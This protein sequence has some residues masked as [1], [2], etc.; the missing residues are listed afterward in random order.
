MTAFRL[1]S[2]GALPL[3]ASDPIPALKGIEEAIQNVT[4][5]RTVDQ[6]AD[7][8]VKTVKGGT[9]SKPRGTP[10]DRGWTYAV[11]FCG[12]NPLF[13][14]LAGYKTL[15][16]SGFEII[17]FEDSVIEAATA[18]ALEIIFEPIGTACAGA[19]PQCRALW[20]PNVEAWVRTG[21][22]SYDGEQVPDL[23]MSGSARKST[24]SFGNYTVSGDL[25]DYLAHWADK[26][27]DI[28]T[29]RSWSYNYMVDCPDETTEDSCR[30]AAI[31][32]QS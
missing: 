27:D 8:V 15:D 2:C 26:F 22:E 24:D 11:T 18:M 10:T 12:Q 23:V 19:T 1:D 21:D 28:K 17:G 14:V 25:P 31:D 20:V 7:N 6:P 16:Y 9:C 29:G 13:E 5:T 30:F 32:S 4:R 3:F